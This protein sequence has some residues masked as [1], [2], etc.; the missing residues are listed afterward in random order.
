MISLRVE[1]FLTSETGS[2]NCWHKS[3][4]ESD[5]SID[6]EVLIIQHCLKLHGLLMES[7]DQIIKFKAGIYL[8]FAYCFTLDSL[9][10]KDNKANLHAALSLTILCCHVWTVNTV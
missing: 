7:N 3:I 2:D 8:F 9:L 6:S 4:M 1:I 5:V 10:K